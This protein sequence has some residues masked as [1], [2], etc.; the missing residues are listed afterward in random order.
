MKKL[1][2]LL[3][4]IS[5]ALSLSAQNEKF[6]KN[7]ELS[8]IRAEGM[9]V[10]GEKLIEYKK[11]KSLLINSDGTVEMIQHGNSHVGNW[12][13]DSESKELKFH[14]KPNETIVVET[15]T[16]RS[17]TTVTAVTISYVV[18]IIDET[19]MVLSMPEVM[20]LKYVPKK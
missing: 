11:D 3:V 14:F 15:E 17:E 8:E 19:Q 4:F 6:V 9:V 13:Y 7:W 16:S 18:D 2:F 1:L 20:T 5:V 10:T 12:E